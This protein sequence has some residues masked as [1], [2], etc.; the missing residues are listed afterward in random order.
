MADNY[1]NRFFNVCGHINKQHICK[2][3]NT[4]SQD[5]MTPAEM[6]SVDLCI[7][8]DAAPWLHIVSYSFHKY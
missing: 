2:K 5:Q 1:V 8:Q 6:E 3:G 7:V 4:V